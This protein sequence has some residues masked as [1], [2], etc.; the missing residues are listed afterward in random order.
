M[1]PGYFSLR[2]GGVFEACCDDLRVASSN[3]L[4]GRGLRLGARRRR[5]SGT[6]VHVPGKHHTGHRVRSSW[7][8]AP[9]PAQTNCV[10]SKPAQSRTYVRAMNGGKQKK[11]WFTARRGLRFLAGRPELLSLERICTSPILSP[12]LTRRDEAKTN[13]APTRKR[14]PYEYKYGVPPAATAVYA[15]S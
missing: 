9:R 12:E 15:P 5:T 10:R 6:E 3:I 14:A 2:G 1:H 13:N 8:G 7:G 11:K 4:G